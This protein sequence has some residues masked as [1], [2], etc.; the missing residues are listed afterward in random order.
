MSATSWQS[1]I[2]S[3]QKVSSDGKPLLFTFAL[4]SFQ[5]SHSSLIWALLF[6]LS[7]PHSRLSRSSC[8]NT[9]LVI[10]FGRFYFLN[11]LFRRGR[12][13]E[14]LRRAA[15]TPKKIQWEEL[16]SELAHSSSS[17]FTL[18]LPHPHGGSS[19][20][21]CLLTP[22][23]RRVLEGQCVKRDEEAET[24]FVSIQWLDISIFI[25]LCETD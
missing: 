25:I 6:F 24:E 23:A 10:Y 9:D 20:V 7:F 14:H 1:W 18:M 5:S 15:A 2:W 11:R 8:W 12:G 17:F 4:V 3:C 13:E 22:S 21:S 16:G 19:R